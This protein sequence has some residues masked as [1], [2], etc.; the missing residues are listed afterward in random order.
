[1]A[2]L[3]NTG[4]TIVPFFQGKAAGPTMGLVESLLAILLVETPAAP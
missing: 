4:S 1:M 3:Q 2:K